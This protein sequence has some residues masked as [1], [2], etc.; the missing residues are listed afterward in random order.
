[1]IPAALAA[2]IP[3]VSGWLMLPFGVLLLL[4][5]VM[6]LAS[7]RMKTWWEHNY[8][9]VAVGL[10]AAGVAFYLLQV[11][12]GPGRVWHAAHEYGSFIVLIGALFVVAGG[13]HLNVKG[14][15][16]PSQNTGFLFI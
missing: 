6:P 4:I 9:L 10:G 1:M 5:A 3:A 15:A 8:W 12:A 13:V 11:E 16:T 14:E 7:A 2:S